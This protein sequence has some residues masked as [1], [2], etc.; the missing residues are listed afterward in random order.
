MCGRLLNLDKFI[1]KFIEEKS[2]QENVIA[3][4]DLLGRSHYEFY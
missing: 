4:D 3:K 1:I 2:F